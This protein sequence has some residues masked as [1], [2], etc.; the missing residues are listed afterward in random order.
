MVS[1]FGASYSFSS[2]TSGD[3]G[4]Y[5]CE[6][7]NSIGATTEIITLDVQCKYVWKLYQIDKYRSESVYI[8]VC[9]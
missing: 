3:S 8:Y 7:Q 2:I 1:A 4:D 9:F 5:T 6:A